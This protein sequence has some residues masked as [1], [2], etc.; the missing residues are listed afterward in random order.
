MNIQ[1]GGFEPPSPV[2]LLEYQ[3]SALNHSANSL[4]ANIQK[5]VD[6]RKKNTKTYIF[7]TIIL[8]FL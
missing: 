8:L 7:L 5:N 6:L 4:S 1:N 3:S 2:G